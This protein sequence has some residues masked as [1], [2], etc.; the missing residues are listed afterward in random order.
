M[1][2]SIDIKIYCK[3]SRGSGFN[4]ELPFEYERPTSPSISYISKHLSLG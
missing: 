3:T 4:S 1:K 2:E